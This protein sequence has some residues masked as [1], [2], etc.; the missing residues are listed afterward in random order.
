MLKKRL[1]YWNYIRCGIQFISFQNKM[2]E[3]VIK[4]KEREIE[5]LTEQYREE[6]EKTAELYKYLALL[7]KP[8]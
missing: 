1:Q 6:K 3:T 7:E 8:V 4:Q 2:L 5:S